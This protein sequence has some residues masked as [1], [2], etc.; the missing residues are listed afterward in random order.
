MSDGTNA[1]PHVSHAAAVS[2]PF[3]SQS[4][5]IKAFEP[6]GNVGE[7]GFA[8][9]LTITNNVDPRPLLGMDDSPRGVILRIAQ[10]VAL[11]SPF[12]STTVVILGCRV[13]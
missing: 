8:P 7:I 3:F 13:K 4:L 1:S 5:V 10:E 2:N 12:R 9:H 6:H 11:E